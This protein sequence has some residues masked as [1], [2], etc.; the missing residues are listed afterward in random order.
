MN[1]ARQS[2]A[3]KNTQFIRRRHSLR[4]AIFLQS[5]HDPAIGSRNGF[6]FQ[7]LAGG[8]QVPAIISSI[9][10][11][12][13]TCLLV[14]VAGYPA[15]AQQAADSVA[16]EFGNE[17]QSATLA[18]ANNY[19]IAAANPLAA[20]AGQEMLAK[21]GSAADALIAAQ[22]VLGLVEPQSSGLGGGAFLLYH[23]AETNKLVTL[24]GRET[25][26]LEATPELFLDDAGQPLRFFDAVI[27]GRSVGTPG[28]VALMAEAHKRFGKLAWKDLFEPAIRLA[29]EGFKVSPRLNELITGS[30]ESL[31]RYEATRNYFLSEEAVP[32]FAGTL[33]RNPEYA[34]SLRAIRDGGAEAF[35]SGE[36]ARDIVKTVREAEGNPGVLSLEDLAAYAVK[37]R[38]P[39]CVT[40]RGFDVCGMGPPSSGGLTVGQILKMLEPYDMT[41]LGPANPQSWRL[42]GDASRLAFADRGRYMADS[43]FV[44][45]PKGL[46]NTD[47]LLERSRL[48]GSSAANP[49]KALTKDEVKAGEPPTDHALLRRD[50]N[51]IELPSTTHLSIVDAQGNVA[52][53]TSTIENGFGSRLMVRG[54][55]LNNELTDFAFDPGEAADPVANRVEPGKRPRSS[56]APT[57]VYR[58]GKPWLAVGSPGGSRIIGYVLKTLVAIID[59]EMD[60]QAAVNLPHLV[61]R[62]GTYDVE[63]GTAAEALAPALTELGYKVEARD[64]NSGLHVIEIGEDGLTGAADPRREGVATGE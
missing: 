51:S 11:C 60:V 62:F 29:E 33:L 15:V 36:I 2:R 55:L 21:G 53:M 40:Y 4:F 56:M 22:W 25:A 58:D 30:A 64:L 9:R 52:S 1:P 10:N 48:I 16:P 14:V 50:D 34:A 44:K 43:D 18:H 12:L 26:P 8:T 63:A 59:W 57:I 3:E 49:G 45:M 35:Y 23:D 61:N 54:F 19:M 41:G 6:A 31:F 7:F 24:D 38:P 46:L 32:L 27:G 20:Q 39:V 47:Y 42:I 17:R 28:T 37:E 13:L 5:V